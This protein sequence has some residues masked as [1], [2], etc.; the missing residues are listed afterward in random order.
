VNR[1]YKKNIISDITKNNFELESFVFDKNLLER[2]VSIS[3]F[4]STFFQEV[5]LVDYNEFEIK[6]FKEDINLFDSDGMDRFN[7]EDIEYIF[8]QFIAIYNFVIENNIDFIDFQSFSIVKVN[9]TIQ[10]KFIIQFNNKFNNKLDYII[11]LF[12][13]NKYFSDLSLSNYKTRFKEYLSLNRK[14]MGFIYRYRDFSSNILDLY[15]LNGINKKSN[16]IIKINSYDDNVYKI[17]KSYLFIDLY[18]DNIIF[19]NFDKSIDS[20]QKN[21]IEKLISLFNLKNKKYGFSDIINELEKNIKISSIKSLI[22]FLDKNINNDEKHFLEYLLKMAP[23]NGIILISFGVELD[24][25]FDLELN[26]NPINYFP[27]SNSL[28]ETKKSKRNKKERDKEDIELI[29]IIDKGDLFNV[30]KITKNRLINRN[31]N[32]NSNELSNVLYKNLLIIKKNE[33]LLALMIDMLFEEEKFDLIETVLKSADKKSLLYRVKITQLYRARREYNEFKY[34][35]LNFLE[36]I[37]ERYISEYYYLKFYYEDKFG[38]NKKADKYYSKIDSDFYKYL[39]DIQLTY[40]LMNIGRLE[41]AYGILKKALVFFENNG[42]ILQKLETEGQIAKY[43]RETGND[44]KA[45][46]IYKSILFVSELKKFNLLTASISLDLGNLYFSFDNFNQSEFWYKRALDGYKNL[47]NNNGILICEFNIS[48]INKYKGEWNKT[49]TF[50]EKSFSIDKREDRKESIAIDSFNISHLEFL[51]KNYDISIKYNNFALRYF[52][53]KNI[54]AGIIETKL[55]YFRL[56]FNDVDKKE[57]ENFEREYLDLCSVEQR[58]IFEILCNIKNGEKKDILKYVNDIKSIRLRFEILV[59]YLNINKDNSTLNLLK[60]ITTKLSKRVR[61][62]FFYEYY[63]MFFSVSSNIDEIIQNNKNLFVDMYYFFLRNGRN[64]SDKIKKIKADLDERDK[65]ENLIDNVKLVGEYDNWETVSDFFNTFSVEFKKK[66]EVD[67]INM[68]IYSKKKHIYEFST[69]NNF[70]D[71]IDELIVKESNLLSSLT[72]SS[73]DINNLK[74]DKK[75]FYP[76]SVTKIYPWKISND[77]FSILVLGFKDL[78]MENIDIYNEHNVLFNR[79]STLFI[80]FYREKIL[81]REKIGFLLG[82]SKAISEVKKKIFKLSERDFSVLITGESG[83][84]KELIAKAIHNLSNRADK[85]F[86]PV[87]IAAIPESLIEAELFGTRKGAFTGA[88][89]DRVG[90]IEYADGGTL[91]LDE[92]GEIPINLQAKLLRTLESGE[93][94]RLGENKIRK[95]DIRLLSATNRNLEEMINNKMFREDLYYRI[96]NIEVKSPPLRKRREDIPLLIRY[97][98]KKYRAG[99]EKEENIIGIIN[100][101]MKFSYK[102]NIRELQSRVKEVIAYYPDYMYDNVNTVD[103]SNKN[104]ADYGLLKLRDEFEKN[105][106]IKVLSENNSNKTLTAKALKIS[107][108]YLMKLIKKYEL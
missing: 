68:N 101:L 16:I 76:Y 91:F 81:N 27:L 55:M 108:T 60:E 107:R 20:I 1:D 72:L 77:I 29:R 102:G 38:D 53:E 25:K 93:I 105:L 85:L 2:I 62:Y 7:K 40:R 30:L 92:I 103:D 99:I 61:N 74:T 80:N 89:E 6:I 83:T 97:F 31:N 15:N 82:K 51:R 59:F 21:M 48:E 49:K 57:F 28:G 10:I 13:K 79:Y 42:Y 70:K 96:A 52:K 104:Y 54:I 64:I 78:V 86:V 17:I 3:D 23:I 58:K 106:I 94:R 75:I 50:L 66:L 46:S 67:F 14:M 24:V 22:I 41:D 9:K 34:S 26:E 47:K 43:Y 100:Y 5:F 12:K 88:N 39:A 56:R 45:E 95:I 69:N 98:L 87:N 71:I 36:E 32:F 84:G 33:E 18:S 19:F 11:K 4:R 73:N 8:V 63:Y 35:V 90:L 65:F 44:K 37:P